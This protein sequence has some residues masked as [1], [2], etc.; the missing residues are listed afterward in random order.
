[1]LKAGVKRTLELKDGFALQLESDP[2]TVVSTAEWVTLERQCCSF[3]KFQLELESDDGGFWLRV[4]GRDG[5]KDFLRSELGLK[6][7]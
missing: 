7:N 4:T 5:I 3:F 6:K 2:A 1:M